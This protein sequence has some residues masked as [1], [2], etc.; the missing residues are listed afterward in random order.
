MTPIVFLD[1]E[2]TGLHPERRAWDIALIRRDESAEI[3]HQWFIEAEDLDLGNAD[4]FALQVSQFYDRHPDYGHSDVVP[5]AEQAVLEAVERLTRGA[6]LVG[7][8]PSFDANVLDRRM[9]A[10]GLLPAWHHHLIDVEA[11]AVG[12]LAA[13]GKT[14]DLPWRSDDL[15][16][17]CGVEPPASN[18]RHTALE[19]ARWAMRWYDAIIGAC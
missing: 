15:S 9:R 16:N 17:A 10:H 4:P 8:V 2:T 12:Y 5:L 18:R 3:R 13:K 7:A 11:L 19:D 1:T 14:V 6:H